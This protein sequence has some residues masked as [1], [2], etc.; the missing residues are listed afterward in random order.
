M[1]M[2]LVAALAVTASCSSDARAEIVNDDKLTIVTTTGILADLTR[3]VVGDNIVVTSIV[4]EG[5]DPHSY[6]PSLRDIR[7]I[8]YADAA[9][10][11]YLLFESHSVI[12]TLDANLAP[13][14]PNIALAEAGVRYA[15][16]TIPLV[17]N[18]SLDTIWLGLRVQ[19]SGE[20][21]GA[22]RTTG[23]NLTA[24]SV[25]G[26]GE[27][28]AYLTETFGDPSFFIDTRDGVGGD[29][30]T[31]LPA[32]AHTHMSWAFTEAGVYT[33]TF[34][35]SLEVDGTV[36]ESENPGTIEFA[37]GV[38]PHSIEGSE[39]KKILNSGHADVSANL[40]VEDGAIQVVY[41]EEGAGI[42][43]QEL[44]EADEVIISVPNSAIHEIP[45]EPR[46]RFLGRAGDT[47]YQLPQAVL[48]AHVHGEIDPH[49][50]HNV[51][52][53]QVY[54][55]VIRDTAIELDPENAAEYTANAEAYL[56]ELEELDNYVRTTI[57]DIPPSRRY[58]VTTHDAFGYFSAAYDI[59]I[60]G[61]VTPN[62]DTEPSVT[63]R[64]RLNE[65]LSQL[66]IPAVF[67]EP[68]LL[69]RSNTLI[70]VADEL[71]L[72]VCEI[73]GDAFDD[74]IDTYIELMTFN[75]DSIHD[76]LTRDR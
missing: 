24:T 70:E 15:A 16:E 51:Y 60:A 74:E 4:P 26:P 23:V 47:V 27:V 11:N 38:D 10:S 72:E 25:T 67:M 43:A 34:T 48:G 53:A 71:D 17:E 9:F 75:A 59:E 66:N 76:C 19:G 64:I 69:S 57:A 55:E 36:I 13:G 5:G 14:T 2:F 21:L 61:F 68:N 28:F 22:D 62:P 37:V 1:V 7:D 6:E 40:E 46:M 44:Y 30:T 65:T 39:D 45:G 18:V 56:L 41:D 3:N 12:R 58:L 35:A 49:L 54:V 29:D 32:G 50:W 20:Q 42:H 33:I 52:N 63:E 31:S 8:A 73:Y